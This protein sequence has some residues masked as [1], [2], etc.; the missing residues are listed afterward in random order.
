MVRRQRRQQEAGS[1]ELVHHLLSLIPYEDLTP[2]RIELTA[3]RT[4]R[5]YIRPP[6]SDQ[7]FVPEVY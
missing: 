1:A 2:T 7:T 4:G 3:A 6:I 5:G